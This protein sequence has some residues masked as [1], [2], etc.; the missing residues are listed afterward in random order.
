MNKALLWIVVGLVLLGGVGVGGRMY[1]TR[2]MDSR[3]VTPNV[4]GMVTP[5]S[6]GLPFA[7][8][9]FESGDRTLIGWWVRAPDVAGAT[10][11]AVLFFHGNRSAIS[12][13]VPLQK[14]FHGQGISSFVFDYTGFGASG[15]SPSLARAVSDAGA[16]ARVFADSA[17]PEA[18]KVAFGSALGSTVLLQGIDSV[19]PHVSGVIV[20]GVAASVREAAV[21][22][23]HVPPFLARFLVDI[24]DNVRA[25]RNVRVPILAVHSYADNRFPIEDAE[26]VLAAVRSRSALVRHRRPGHSAILAS[27]RPCDWAQVLDFVKAGTLPA[28]NPDTVDVCVALEEAATARA[29]SIARINA[30]AAAAV[31]ERRAAIQRG[32][33]TKAAPPAARRP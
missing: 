15:G 33:S 18:R 7:R 4:M 13:Y 17:G 6:A 30:A 12:D 28:A 32:A 20:E 24:A 1:A 10:P 22:D 26:R 19:Q 21:R 9:A 29:D 27:S 25:A 5:D 8:L 16:A 11:P 14:F 3:A 2:L 23:G 31:A